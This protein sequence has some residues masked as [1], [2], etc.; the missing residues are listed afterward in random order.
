MHTSP[1]KLT[2]PDTTP[3]KANS[4][5]SDTLEGQRS[6]QQPLTEAAG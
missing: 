2:L 1:E 4:P 3:T 6:Q 5:E